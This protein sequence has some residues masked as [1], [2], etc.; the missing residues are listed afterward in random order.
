MSRNNSETFSLHFNGRN[1][2]N[3]KLRVLIIA[4]QKK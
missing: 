1:N 4:M 2:R 3:D